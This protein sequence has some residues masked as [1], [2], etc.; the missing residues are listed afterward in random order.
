MTSRFLFS[1]KLFDP[2]ILDCEALHYCSLPYCHAAC[3][4]YGVWVDTKEVE[5]I[6]SHSDLI[7]EFLPLERQDPNFW[8]A[9]EMEEDEFM[10]SGKVIH[11][12]LV[13]DK[14]F[15][16]GSACIFL[17]NDD[18]CALQT[19]AESAQ[20][21]PWQ[22]KPAYC[23][24]H[25]LDL[26][27]EGGI[28]LPETDWLLEGVSKCM[29][30]GDHA[31]P[32]VMIFETELRYLIGDLEYENLLKQNGLGSFVSK[33]FHGL[34]IGSSGCGVNTKEQPDGCGEQGCQQN[35]IQAD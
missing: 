28:T 19:A 9:A 32:F 14:A 22:L 24:L 2:R 23:I 18:C 17:R 26:D 5:N 31:V 20:L 25:P 30:S 8:F 11:S 33:C 29:S 15:S 16:N 27:I 6:L 10:P 12:S 1:S 7:R 21:H 13:T 35:C 3:C 34:K 4:T